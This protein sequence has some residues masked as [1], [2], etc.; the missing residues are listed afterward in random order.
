[1][2]SDL[3]I[4]VFIAEDP[5]LALI[6]RFV[7]ADRGVA[8]SNEAFLRDQVAALQAYV[9]QFPGSEKQVRAI[10]WIENR[11]REYRKSWQRRHVTQRLKEQRCADC[12]LRDVQQIQHCEIHG[13][14]AGLLNRY[15]A[16]RITSREYVEEALLLLS[17]HK[18][19]LQQRS[20]LAGPD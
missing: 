10:E 19:E 9:G 18:N 7:G 4:I 15:T 2:A 20:V 12:P 16:D 13:R 3:L 11:A 14:W 17:E 5:M 6:A 8:L 1:M